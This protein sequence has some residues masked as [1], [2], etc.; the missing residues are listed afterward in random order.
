[1][2]SSDLT[3]FYYYLLIVTDLLPNNLSKCIYLDLD[4]C[5]CKDLTE[6]FNI[7]IKDNL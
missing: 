7:D 1:M 4:I 2:N 5:F 6:L 3:S